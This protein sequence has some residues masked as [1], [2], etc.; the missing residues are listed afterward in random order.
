MICVLII[1]LY[2]L[3]TQSVFQKIS[4]FL[5]HSFVSRW[6]DAAGLVNNA[7]NCQVHR[8]FLTNNDDSQDIRNDATGSEKMTEITYMSHLFQIVSNCDYRQSNKLIVYYS[9]WSMTTINQ[10]SWSTSILNLGKKLFVL[11]IFTLFTGETVS[12][13]KWQELI[14][15]ITGN[16]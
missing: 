8:S 2:I 11:I 1:A 5:C 10:H 6:R 16:V 12:W 15:K 3:Y 14:N 9:V 13:D 7:D 4:E